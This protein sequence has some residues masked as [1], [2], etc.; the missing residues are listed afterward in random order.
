MKK[1]TGLLLVFTVVL[2]G[3]SASN[4]LSVSELASVTT[5]SF[6]TVINDT[7]A[8][9]TTISDA[10]V[11]DVAVVT[12][13]LT[14]LSDQIG[15]VITSYTNIDVSPANQ[16]VHQ[17]SIMALSTFQIA[18]TAVLSTVS[19]TGT[20]SAEAFDTF[21]ATFTTFTTSFNEVI[22]KIDAI[23]QAQSL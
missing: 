19:Q 6:Q 8:A 11:S 14:T 10:G 13:T 21:K 4:Q 23:A 9:I 2:V 16:T 7:N 12:S 1:L 5:S 17:I 3:C 18:V 22:V 15:A 20:L